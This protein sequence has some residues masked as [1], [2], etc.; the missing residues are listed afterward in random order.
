MAEWWWK[1]EY[2]ETC[3]CAYGCPCNLNSIPTD[4]TCQAIDAWLIRE[5]TFKDTRLDGLGIGL[6]VRWPN[7]IHEGNG[8][9]VVFID[10][11]ADEAQRKALEQIGTGKAG[12]GGPFEIFA[13][14]YS[15]PPQVVYGPVQLERNGKRATIRFGD[16]GQADLGP[17]ISAMDGQEAEISMVMPGG[18]I[19]KD[20]LM[21]NTDRCEVKTDSLDFQ[22]KD[23]SAFLSAVEYNV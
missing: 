15:E 1:A 14:T 6:L 21:V 19:W 20:G 23:S 2:Y 9:A 16:M 17:V 12:P 10:E 22:H 13:S 8:K 7:P 11:R 18:F 5:G 4:G 3:N